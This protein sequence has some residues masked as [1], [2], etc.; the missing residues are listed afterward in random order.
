MPIIYLFLVATCLQVPPRATAQV[1]LEAKVAAAATLGALWIV[2]GS[3]ALEKS[4]TWLCARHCDGQITLAC[5]PTSKTP[6]EVVV[7][8]KVEIFS[9]SFATSAH[10][11]PSMHSLNPPAQ[12]STL[13]ACVVAEGEESPWR[14][15]HANQAL[16]THCLPRP[17]R[18]VATSRGASARRRFALARWHFAARRSVARRSGPH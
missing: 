16:A 12:R 3:F 8:S 15:F 18:A 5:W 17:W 10:S 9:F 4:P 6:R 7:R 1:S 13:T 14:A 11:C 2:P